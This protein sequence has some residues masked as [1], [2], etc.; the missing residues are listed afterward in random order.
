MNIKYRIS[1][2]VLGLL[3]ILGYVYWEHKTFK[4]GAHRCEVSDGMMVTLYAQL[5]TSKGSVFDVANAAL[6]MCHLTSGQMCF[7]NEC[8]FVKK[9]DMETPL[10]EPNIDLPKPPITPK[11]QPKKPDMLI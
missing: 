11:E 6:L 8:K 10:A 2:L 1:I 7:I 3:A 4:E 9:E 5:P